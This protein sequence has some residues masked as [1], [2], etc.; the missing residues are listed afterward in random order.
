MP[1]LLQINVTA[2]WGS[3][4][5]I[6]EQ[7]GWCA[8]SRGWD[9]YLAYGR[10]MNPSKNKLIKIG[11]NANVYA[12]YVENIILD[13]EGLSS[14]RA[15]RYFLAIIDTIKP[16]I[17][18]LHNIHDHYINFRLLFR[19]LAE[20]RITV[21][22]TQHDQWATTGHCMYT[23]TDC[24]RWKD[25]CYD[26]PLSKWFCIDQSCR[27]HQ[28]KKE[29]LKD[30]QS[31]IIVPVSNWLAENIRESFLK[32]H[33]MK[34]IH[35]GVDINVFYPR[36]SDILDR[37]GISNDMKIVLGV[38]AVWDSRKGLSDFIKLSSFL[39]SDEYVIVVV[40]K[41][42]ENITFSKGNKQILFIDR[43]QDVEELAQLYSAANVF[44]NPTYQ[45]NFPTTNLEALACGTP[46]ITYRTGGSPESID[47]KT[48]IVVEP[49]DVESLA[50]AIVGLKNNP[51]SSK[52]CRAR[53]EEC[54]DKDKC[55]EKYI[56]LYETLI[57]NAE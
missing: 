17:V 22:W 6:A 8:Q 39:P 48:G 20:K 35:N 25:T 2:N 19:Y 18:H 53:A 44:V 9:S 5:K 55:F 33:K 11:S 23:P 54:F 12:H 47:E 14:R 37:I 46:V 16:D 26:C 49:G 41:L 7:I 38:A 24:N 42:T 4:G 40:G 52:D 50:Q 28:L 15:T 51:L 3:T 34:V 43:T 30:F 21:V 29:L 27:N 36:Q 57:Q 31:L 56:E 45:D 13:N 1:R 10:M 32:A